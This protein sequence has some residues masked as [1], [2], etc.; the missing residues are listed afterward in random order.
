MLN[1]IANPPVLGFGM[2][3]SA[4]A[5]MISLAALVYGESGKGFRSVLA[6]FTYYFLLFHNPPAI[7]SACM[8]SELKGYLSEDDS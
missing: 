5:H 8:E 4:T 7:A 2:G 6:T 1:E 3:K